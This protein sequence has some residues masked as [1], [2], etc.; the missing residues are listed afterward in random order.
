MKIKKGFTLRTVMGQDVVMAEGEN[1]D[2]FGK[3]IKLNKS[4]AT[5]WKELQGRTFDAEAAADVLV[6]H[7]GIDRA[8][9]LADAQDILALMTQKGLLS[10]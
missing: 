2:S 1:A 3:I 4:A 8:L 5:L 7:Y 9:A 10:D 6:A